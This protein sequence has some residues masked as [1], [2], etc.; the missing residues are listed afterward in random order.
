M[1][2]NITDEL[3]TIPPLTSTDRKVAAT[4]TGPNDSAIEEAKLFELGLDEEDIKKRAN[5]REHRRN[6]LFRDHFE[7]IAI[8]FLYLIAFLFFAVGFSWFWH[9]LTPGS[10][11]YL[12][13]DQVS[14]L[15][16]IVTGGILASIAAGHIKKRLT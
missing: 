1:S 16:N 13:T 14:K 12:S 5:E 11:H 7:N 6:E 2:G 4:F 9:L 3:K 15:Q 8:A 10:W